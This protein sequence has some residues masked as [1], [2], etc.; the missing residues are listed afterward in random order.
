VAAGA[1]FTGPSAAAARTRHALSSG[2]GRL[3]PGG[4]S[5]PASRWTYAHR[6]A[7]RIG[8]VA[9]ATLVFVFWGQPTAAAVVAIAVLLLAVLVRQRQFV[10]FDVSRGERHGHRVI[11]RGCVDAR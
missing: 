4:D 3:R 2:L 7:L 8:A 9:L 6:T 10:I 1:F 11:I 5:G